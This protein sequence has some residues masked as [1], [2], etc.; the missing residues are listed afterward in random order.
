[1]MLVKTT[2]TLY[3]RKLNWHWHS[4]WKQYKSK[5]YTKMAYAETVCNPKPWNWMIRS[6]QNSP[7]ALCL[8]I[9]LTRYHSAKSVTKLAIPFNVSR[10]TCQIRK[11]AG[12]GCAGMP[13]TFSP[14]PQVSDPDINHGTCVT[15]VPWCMPGSLTSVFFW[16]RWRG[17]R[18]RHSRRMHNTKFCVSGKRPIERSPVQVAMNGT[19]FLS[20]CISRGDIFYRKDARV[21]KHDSR[22][23]VPELGNC[24]STK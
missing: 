20:S 24:I 17:K 10:A 13:G 5:L 6:C 22:T 1:M 11:I 23:L 3:L 19:Y 2:I 9:R 21:K 4:L 14:P 15:H 18:F 12:F 7:I 16:S 8:Y